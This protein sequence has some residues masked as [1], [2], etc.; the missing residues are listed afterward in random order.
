MSVRDG[1]DT[2]RRYVDRAGGSVEL[3]LGDQQSGLVV[4][5]G[6]VSGGGIFRT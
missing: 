6:T 1:D 2:R 3:R 4:Q 5:P